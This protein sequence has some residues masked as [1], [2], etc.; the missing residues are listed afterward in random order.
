V[1]QNKLAVSVEE[2]AGMLSVST[3]TMRSWIADGR[4]RAVHLGR[5]V[6]VPVVE[7]ER[8]IAA[9]TTPSEQSSAE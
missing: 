5:R 4:V 9:H 1:Q 7:L 2:G 8:L 3:R 6:V